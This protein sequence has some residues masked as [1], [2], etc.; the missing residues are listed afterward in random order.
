MKWLRRMALP[1]A[2]CFLGMQASAG[3][4]IRHDPVPATFFGWVI[5][6]AHIN[7]AWPEV[8][9]WYMAVVGFL[10]EMERCRTAGRC[11]QV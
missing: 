8:P 10:P 1:A 7:T 3:V 9:F 6:R 11:F 2:I 5:Q 4:V